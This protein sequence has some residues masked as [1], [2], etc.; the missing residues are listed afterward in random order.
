M[1]ATPMLYWSRPTL[2]KELDGALIFWVGISCG[3][4]DLVRWKTERILSMIQRRGFGVIVDVG[5]SGAQP[6]NN[7]YRQHCNG[8]RLSDYQGAHRLELAH[9]HL[10][11]KKRRRPALKIGERSGNPRF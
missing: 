9:I 3:R 11:V 5:E 4:G 6:E 2:L 8:G 7:N 1:W 10:Y